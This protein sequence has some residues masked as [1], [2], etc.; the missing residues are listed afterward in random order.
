MEDEATRVARARER[1]KKAKS[2]A[3]DISKNQTIA[4][5]D[6]IRSHGVVGMAVGLAIGASVGA[7]VKT[8]V[9]SFITPLVRF[10]VGSQGRLESNVWHVDLW[11]RQADFAWGAALSAIITLFATILAIYW[12]V[13]IFKLD[14]L[15]KK[16]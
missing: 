8:L 13:H 11:G 7:T 4:F 6:F 16:S 14:R 15:D 3:G 2:K 9:E 10:I 1:A 5:I 12:V